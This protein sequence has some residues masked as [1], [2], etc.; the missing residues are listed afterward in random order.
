MPRSLSIC[1]IPLVALAAVLSSCSPVKFSA[2]NNSTS[3]TNS[4][5]VV[6]AGSGISCS[7]SL[8]GSAAAFS[9]TTTGANPTLA[10]NCTPSGVT[11]A[12]SVTR[13]GNPVTIN[14]L[15][16]AS[17]VPD[18]AAAGVGVY[19]ITLNATS[20]GY[21]PYSSATPLQVTVT[22]AGGPPMGTIVCDP[23]LNGTATSV[24]LSTTNPTVT[25]SCTPSAGV[26]YAWTVTRSG[27]AVTI[28][29]LSGS[30]ATADFLAAGPGTYLIYLS[31]TATNYNP[32]NSTTPLTVTV[33]AAPTGTAVHDVFNVTTSNNKLD[34]LLVVDDSSSM[35]ADNQRLA[36]RMQGFVNDLT[37]QG[38]DWQ[39]CATVTN[40]VRVSASDPAYYWGA[41]QNWSGNPN[42]PAW[43]LKSGTANTNQIFTNTIN[44]IGAG[45]A[46][47]DDER[48]IKAAYWHAYNGEIGVAGS[49]GCYRPDA[50]LAV[51]IL[52]DE[53]ERSIGGDATQ[54]VYDSEANKPLDPID[55]Y[56]QSYVDQVKRI[57]GNS[58]R[59]TV[60]SI[61]VRPSDTT[62]KAQQDAEGSASHYGV[63]YA[64]LSSLTSGY[65]GSIC[66]TDY[67]TNLNYFKSVI[68]KSQAS[69]P[70]QCSAPTNMNVTVTPTYTYTSNISNS[71]IVFTPQVNS[72]SSVDLKYICP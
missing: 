42:N 6:P 66:D 59:F 23:K 18:F 43:I 11:Y 53:D 58:K 38:F 1:L 60:N 36:S 32:Y 55:D 8:N 22:S 61:I 7:P 26:A 34:I 13:G 44:A 4:T 46:G 51:I 39:M 62:C 37:A 2:E 70:L 30:S 47:T 25:A 17:S 20:V 50:G 19:L 65:T 3:G 14:G 64:E 52:S 49:S 63:K 5:P 10:A 68:I 67:S 35:L 72:G 21:N 41:S 57:F 29:G 40:A 71:K 16:G 15:T 54:K 56:P 31:A 33:P 12:W 24:T 69:F 28:S 9:M 48:A 27:T 45:W